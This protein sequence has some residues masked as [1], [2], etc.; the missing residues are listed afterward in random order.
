MVHQSV[1][2]ADLIAAMNIPA[3]FM[4]AFMQEILPPQKLRIVSRLRPE[5]KRL[6]KLAKVTWLFRKL[7]LFIKTRF[8]LAPSLLKELT[9]S[10]SHCRVEKGTTF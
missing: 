5:N 3:H 4:N 8:Y 7:V 1:V 6:I 9:L 10:S 2:S